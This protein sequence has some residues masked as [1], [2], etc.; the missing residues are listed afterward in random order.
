M[1]E[2]VPLLLLIAAGYGWR[3]INPGGIDAAGL[4]RHLNALL[5]YLLVPAM[6]F[7]VM[8]TAPLD[9]HLLLVVLSGWITIGACG[10]LGYGLHRV[11]QRFS[12]L[13]AGT[14]GALV[15]A[16]IFGNG[17]GAALPVLHELYHGEHDE[18]VL[19]FE[20]LATIP[21]A[22][23]IGVYVATRFGDRGTIH[24]LRQILSLPPIWALVLALAYNV[25]G[26][27]IP[28]LISPA[29]DLLGNAV[30]AL[31][32]L[33]LGMALDFRTTPAL[34]WL[35]LPAFIRVAA[36]LVCGIVLGAMF[37]FPPA[38]RPALIWICAAPSFLM[39]LVFCD[40]FGLDTAAF[41]L[42][43]SISVVIYLA[44]VPFALRALSG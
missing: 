26:L 2:L 25:L 18:L 22:W 31:M 32:L 24:P 8:A 19:G 21:L 9:R 10:L 16:S 4:R 41:A 23:T 37:D 40:R 34:A 15:L 27:S 35:G 30:L 39:G 12:G 11:L 5:I 36:G 7:R 33:T 38:D 43:M 3:S 44:L 1:Q 29:F 28:P 14:R 42:A 13:P 6:V 20:L 17:L